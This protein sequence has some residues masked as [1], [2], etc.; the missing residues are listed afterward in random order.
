[1]K[2]ILAILFFACSTSFGQ[3]MKEIVKSIYFGGG[4]YHVDQNQA[5]QLSDLVNSLNNLEY[6]EIN[7]MSHTDPIGGRQFNE[8]LSKMRSQSAI[9]L[10]KTLDIPQEKIR[11]KDFAFEA[12]AYDNNT[13]EGRAR[14]RRVDI[15]FKPIV[16]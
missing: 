8:Y 9:N 11:F 16:F 4:S 12:P 13:W 1:M 15:Q 3:E 14:N 5:Q 10:L 7:I 2:T 6:Y